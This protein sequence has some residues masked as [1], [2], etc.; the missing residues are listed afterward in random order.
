M[1]GQ[2]EER[3]GTPLEAIIDDLLAAEPFLLPDEEV[4]G[5]SFEDSDWDE[6]LLW[7]TD[8][9]TDPAAGLHERMTWYW[10]THFTSSLD[11]SSQRS[12]WIQHHLLRNHALGNFRDL[13]QAIAV[14]GAM[15]QYLDG[16]YSTG[17][18]PN[19]NFARE[20][21]ELFTLGAGNYT[22]DDIRVAARGFSGWAVDWETGEVT[23]DAERH[24]G[25]PLE[26][27][28]IRRRWDAESL[29][30]AILDQ[31]A[32]AAHVA[33]R[34]H[35]HLVGTDPSP[36][37]RSELA[38][39]FRGADY[40]ILPLVE[41]ILRHADFRDAIQARPR[42]P[43]EWLVAMLGA[44]GHLDSELEIWWL[45][46]LGQVPMSPPNV[47]GWPDG[48]RW[49]A[50]SQML[51]RTTR[52]I[53][54]ELPDSLYDEVPATIDAV[55]DRCGIYDPSPATLA[56]LERAARAQPEYENGLEMLMTLALTSPE[57]SLA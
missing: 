34:I 52:V 33:G 36:A 57:F 47:A 10:H 31:P 3:V 15:L 9:L 43:L 53:E 7:W 6:V 51:L 17:D 44:T 20:L 2:V 5:R 12:M 38:A 54:L 35:R 41:A 11:K 55:L 56:A 26:F 27:M 25:R 45:D 1:P 30:D 14:D 39:V 18:A 22:E 37:R 23:F 29:I 40:E 49:L 50:A 32:C 4:K 42:Q 16:S 19:E 48:E 24:Y 46:L 28:G 13:C 8:R 21:M